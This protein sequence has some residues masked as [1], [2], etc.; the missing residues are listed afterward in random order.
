M[1]LYE[2]TE[3]YMTLMEMAE[4]PETDP[5]TLADT[6]DA[7]TG[8]IED[9]ADSYAVIINSLKSD[10]DVLDAEI[11]RLTARTAAMLAN[12]ERMKSRLMTAMIMAGREK[13][14][15]ARYT[16][17]IQKT[18]PSVVLDTDDLEKIS[19][20][21]LIRQDPKIDKRGI[22]AALKGGKDLPGVAHLEQCVALRIR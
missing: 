7:I 3:Q 15:T 1:T 4:D 22:A 20:E 19:A 5:Q 8:E 17:G 13:I 14:K 2:L 21:Y 12:A 9:K 11:K 6:M 10:A 16:L 18:T